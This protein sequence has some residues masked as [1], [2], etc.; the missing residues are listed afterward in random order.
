MDWVIARLQEPSTWN[1]IT[2]ILTIV[3]VSLLPEQSTAI[4]KAGVAVFGAVA[5]IKKE[6]K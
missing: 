4:I 6:S 3:G 2:A 5:V 1:G